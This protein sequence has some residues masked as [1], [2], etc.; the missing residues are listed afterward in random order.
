MSSDQL[1][2]AF[3]KGSW[4]KFPDEHKRTFLALAKED[5]R[6][7]IN[8]LTFATEIDRTKINASVSALEALQLIQVSQSGVAKICELSGLGWD[9][10]QIVLKLNVEGE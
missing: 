4:D 10:A 6:M 9:F 7:P 8:K 2:L 5:L 3:I 1:I